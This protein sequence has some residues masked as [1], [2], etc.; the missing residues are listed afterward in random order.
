MKQKLGYRLKTPAVTLV[1]KPQNL[2][3]AQLMNVIP[4]VISNQNAV[5]AFAIGFYIR[6]NL[7]IFGF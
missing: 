4:R 1:Q 6:L 7:V 5:F 3:W 2:F